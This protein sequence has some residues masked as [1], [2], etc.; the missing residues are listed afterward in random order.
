MRRCGSPQ[1]ARRWWGAATES[2]RHG[3]ER[4]V[5]FENVA[6]DASW[7]THKQASW[8]RG[9]HW[10]SLFLPSQAPLWFICSSVHQP[11]PSM[12]TRIPSPASGSIGC[13]S[14]TAA[15]L[16]HGITLSWRSPF[17]LCCLHQPP[18]KEAPAWRYTGGQSL[19]PWLF[20]VS[21]PLFILPSPRPPPSH[22]QTP[23]ITSSRKLPEIA[24][25]A[26]LSALCCSHT[27]CFITCHWLI[28][29]LLLHCTGC[30]STAEMF[31][32]PWD[33]S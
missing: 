3:L 21:K 9:P 6:K 8:K 18:Q 20:H 15:P 32:P 17:I 28:V 16:L 5:S 19:A 24:S 7:K 22:T 26:T 2:R 11:G 31:H 27:L 4:N 33:S 1:A 14:P 29:A 12:R 23:C 25:P 13:C 30:S 10:L